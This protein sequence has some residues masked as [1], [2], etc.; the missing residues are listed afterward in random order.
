MKKI[1]LMKSKEFATYVKKIDTDKNDKN[2][3]K[4]YHK[5]RDHC[6]YAGKHRGSAHG[7][8]SLRYKIPKEISTVFD[9]GS[10]KIITS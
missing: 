10:T 5:V 7:I 1:S 9:N 6:H 3:F 2:A 8:C 4:L